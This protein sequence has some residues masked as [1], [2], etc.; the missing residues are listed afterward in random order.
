MQVVVFYSCIRSR[1]SATTNIIPLFVHIFLKIL[2]R[3]RELTL[4]N[5][6]G[7]HYNIF[8][9]K[10][11]KRIYLFEVSFRYKLTVLICGITRTEE[12]KAMI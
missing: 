10:N 11:L 8:A 1:E 9:K 4:V 3:K 12:F 6:I 5:V 7:W 2:F